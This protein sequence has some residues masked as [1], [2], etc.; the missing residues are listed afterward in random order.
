MSTLSYEIC[1]LYNQ[2]TQYVEQEYQEIIYQLKHEP[3]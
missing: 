2:I 3:K 1:V